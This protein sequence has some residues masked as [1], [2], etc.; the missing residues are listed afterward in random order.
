MWAFT[1]LHDIIALLM[2]A[3]GLSTPLQCEDK[4]HCRECDFVTWRNNLLTR[5]IHT[6]TAAIRL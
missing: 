4:L 1:P 2:T 6:R 3:W 5:Y